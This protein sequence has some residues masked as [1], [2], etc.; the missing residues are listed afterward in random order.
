M[1]ATGVSGLRGMES[2]FYPPTPGGGA[3]G[4]WWGGSWMAPEFSMLGAYE[5]LPASASQW[6]A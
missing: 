1:A 3:G 5:A 4:G 6:A 2:G